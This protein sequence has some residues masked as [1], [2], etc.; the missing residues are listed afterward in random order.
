[1]RMRGLYVL[2][3]VRRGFADRKHFVDSGRRV[4]EIV[5]FPRIESLLRL[6]VVGFDVVESAW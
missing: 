5:R 1:M 6:P 4:G 2:A 3:K